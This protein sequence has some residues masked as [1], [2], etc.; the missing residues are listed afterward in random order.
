MNTT[1]RTTP[2]RKN[3]L[4][5]VS[6]AGGRFRRKCLVGMGCLSVTKR[7]FGPVEGVP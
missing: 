6:L 7:F 3:R 4:W 2:E 1:N 5:G